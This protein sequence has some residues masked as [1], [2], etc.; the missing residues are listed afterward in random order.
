MG[1]APWEDGNFLKPFNDS[2]Y[3]KWPWCTP[4]WYPDALLDVPDS[5]VPLIP[6]G[7]T[8]PLFVEVCV[9]YGQ[10][11]GNYS[12]AVTVSA[13]RSSVAL[14]TVPILLEVWDIDLP[15]IA[16]SDAFDTAFA[17][18]PLWCTEFGDCPDTVPGKAWYP[19]LTHSEISDTWLRFLAKHRIPGD[20]M[21]IQTPRPV[22]EYVAAADIGIKNM[23]LQNVGLPSYVLN[24]TTNKPYANKSHTPAVIASLLAS[25]DP[26]VAKLRSLGLLQKAYVYGWDELPY[27]PFANLS[28]R[29]IF[30]AFKARYPDLRTIATLNWPTICMGCHGAPTTPNALGNTYRG[31]PNGPAPGAPDGIADDFP[32][33]VWVMEY[34]EYGQS[35][36]YRTPT[37]AEKARQRWL[38]AKESHRYW[39]YWC[40]SPRPP[41]LMNT[42]VE[43]PA[44]DTRLMYW[45]AGLHGIDGMLYYAVNLWYNQC[46]G[47]HLNRPCKPMTRINQTA[48]T[49]VSLMRSRR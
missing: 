44:I 34:G 26:I 40:I 9:P 22:S 10:A 49:D 16:D 15:A 17:F 6:V 4:G 3:L 42:F 14:F 28:I 47:N 45:L 41:E 20:D 11:A 32:I 35:N 8:Q 2:T 18:G 30:G 48:L 29:T 7:F 23:N 21:Y 37:P 19:N 13:G 43:R 31:G 1:G 12:G 39:W 36:H 5:G 24:S 46:D 33:D 27:G 25:V 38:V